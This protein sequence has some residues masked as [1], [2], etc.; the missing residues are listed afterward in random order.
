MAR[1]RWT[2][3]VEQLDDAISQANEDLAQLTPRHDATLPVALAPWPIVIDV[4]STEIPAE[5]TIR[6]GRE[7]MRF[8]ED[9][10]WSERGHQLALPT[11]R[12]VEGDVASLV[13]NDLGPDTRELLVSHLSNGFSIIANDSLRRAVEGEPLLDLTLDRLTQSCD[14][15][16]GWLDPLGRCSSCAELDWRRNQITAAIARLI[17]ERDDVIAD[18]ERMRERLPVFRRQL[19]DVERDIDELRSKGVEPD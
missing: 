4:R 8:C 14:R 15:C 2:D 6:V 19:Q 3:R 9:V 10:D 11:L 17:D 18:Q 5:I 1:N 13:S 7:M 12:Q 16:G